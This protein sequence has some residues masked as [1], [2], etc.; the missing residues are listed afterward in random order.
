MQD[1]RGMIAAEAM[2][3]GAAMVVNSNTGVLARAD[4]VEDGVTGR[5]YRMVDSAELGTIV[6][7]LLQTPGALAS[8]RREGVIRDAEHGPDALAGALEWAALTIGAHG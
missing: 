8:L 4:L 5:V 3:A 7:Q 2:A 6:G 1:N